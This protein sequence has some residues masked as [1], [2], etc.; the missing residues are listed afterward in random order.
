MAWTEDRVETLR[1]LWGD[2]L[3]ASQIAEQL[4]G[5]T[6]NAVIGK[7]HRLGLSGRPSPLKGGRPKGGNSSA[8]TS[9]ATPQVATPQAQQA[10]TATARPA[11]ES[12]PAEREPVADPV[13]AEVTANAV[14][15]ARPSA[16]NVTLLNLTDRMCKWPIGH[17]GDKDFRFCGTKA[18]GGSPYCAEHAE[19]AYQPAQSRR[20][21]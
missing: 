14:A 7:A 15:V 5:V 13:A 18:D 10:K 17:P 8:A 11:P 4:G 21:A 3:S 1:Q 2:G 19:Q 6:R 9:R 20:R 12:I 16:D